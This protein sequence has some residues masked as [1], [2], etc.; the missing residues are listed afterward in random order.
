M[1]G[2]V[3]KSGSYDKTLEKY[4]IKNMLRV[5]T[6]Y[7]EIKSGKHKKYQYVEELFKANGMCRQN[8]H[9]YYKRYL[10]N[11]RD[12]NQ[13]LPKKRGSRFKAPSELYSEDILAKIRLFR[14]D[15]H[16]KY[17][18][19]SQLKSKLNLE[20]SSS[21]IY[22][23]TRKMGLS[24]INRSIKEKVIKIVKSKRGELGHV[25]IHYLPKDIIKGSDK[26]LYLL[27]IIDDYSRLCWLDVIGSTKSL[28][29]MFS[30]MEILG[31]LRNRYEIE[32]KEMLSDNG[33]EFASKKNISNHPF[34]KLLEF[35]SIKHRYTRPYRPQ[36]N[37]K[38]E[39]FWRTIKEELLEDEQFD[40][41][42]EL[43]EF[44]TGYNIYYNEERMHQGIN[45]KVPI[46]M[47]EK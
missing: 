3:D 41:V 4:H 35:M 42:D 47:I 40:S 1:M 2:R 44:I 15:G 43:K 21:T 11:N 14:E 9:K 32:F 20:I 28:D 16:N 29:V 27:G 25:D 5:F 23:L 37:G 10:L 26:R 8:F 7:E 34:E 45:G 6:E 36:T 39:R 38:I 19:A 13:L 12:I 22:R 46:N 31:I 30:S 24:K 33:S 18:I 17:Y